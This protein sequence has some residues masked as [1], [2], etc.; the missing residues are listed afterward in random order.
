MAHIGYN[1]EEV[2]ATPSG[3]RAH[4]P[5]VEEPYP[6]LVEDDESEDEQ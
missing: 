3:L 4:T 6:W 5:A 1:Y 2:Q